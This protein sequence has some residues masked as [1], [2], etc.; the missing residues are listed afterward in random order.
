MKWPAPFRDFFCSPVLLSKGL[1]IDLGTTKTRIYIPG[2]GIVINEPSLVAIR[3]ASGQI[4]A[5]GELAKEMLGR[6]PSSIKVIKPLKD[7]VIA[8]FHAAEA[9]LRFFIRKSIRVGFLRRPRI[10]VSIPSETSPVEQRAVMEAA[11]RAK[12]SDVS[13]VEQP[14]MAAIG[15]GMPV[16]SALGNMIVDIGGGTTDIAIISLGDAVYSHTLRSA[17]NGMDDAIIS[18]LKRECAILIG[19]LTAERVKIEIGSA[20]P[21]KPKSLE[22]AGR[23]LTTGLPKR[24]TIHEEPIR[25]AL[26]RCVFDIVAGIQ[27]ALEVTP[28]ELCA[29]I[30]HR[31]ITLTG[32]GALLTNL[33]Q[34]IERDVG[35]PA[36]LAEDPLNAVVLGTAKILR[37]PDFLSRVALGKHGSLLK[38]A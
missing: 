7:G 13:V 23:D 21:S 30:A 4:V 12:A 1:A 6:T 3:E 22:I 32:G 19:E 11:Y 9:L 29:D 8:N 35:L 14:V 18:Y 25:N 10:V 34:R 17:G 38:A 28:P 31:G 5:F 24:V 37:E 33:S 16:T 36:V 15:A 2:R 27:Y 26:E 20:L